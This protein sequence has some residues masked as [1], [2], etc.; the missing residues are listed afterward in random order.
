MTDAT[1][2]IDARKSATDDLFRRKRLIAF[3]VPAVILVYFVYIFFAFDVP[4]LWQRASAE[5]AQTLLRDVYSYK[6]HVER[7]NRS[8]EIEAAKEG[9][10]KGSYPDGTFPSWVSFD[11]D[12]TVIELKGGVVVTFGPD[13]TATWDGPDFELNASAS[14]SGGVQIDHDPDTLPE[15]VSYSKS[16]LQIT[17]EAGRLT[18]TR[19]RTEVFRYFFGWELFFFTLDSPYHDRSFTEIFFGPQIDPARSNVAGAVHD[20]WNNAMW[21]HKDVLWAIGETILMAFLGTMGAAIVALPLGF[22]AAKNFTPLAPLRF[23]VR[24]LFDFV[25]GVDALI[26]TILLSRAFGPGPLTGSAGDPVYR[27][28]DLREAVLR[29]IG[30]RG[31]EADRGCVID[32]REPR[33]AL[34]VRGDPADHAGA[35]EPGALLP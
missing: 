25:R 14:R 33:P 15:F 10:R 35:S 24:R 12:D 8:G 31:Q 11:G 7:D 28:R 30:K 29:G 5:N 27:Y 6:V 4:G 17:T 22:L 18:M 21:R 23:A 20:V 1:L 2:T 9:E 3:S 16:R 32:G 34:P 26:W 13:N 19:N